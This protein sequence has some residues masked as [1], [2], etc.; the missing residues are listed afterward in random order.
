MLWCFDMCS[1]RPLFLA[2]PATNFVSKFWQAPLWS[3][4]LLASGSARPKHR[5][6]WRFFHSLCPL[7][8]ICLT[9][10]A[11]WI[12]P[13]KPTCGRC[14]VYRLQRLLLGRFTSGSFLANSNLLCLT[15]KFL[16]PCALHM[17]GQQQA[18]SE[19]RRTF[20]PV[21]I[22]FMMPMLLTSANVNIP[23][24]PHP[25][26][27]VASSTCAR[28]TETQLRSMQHVCNF[29]ERW[30]P[31]PT[32]PHPPKARKTQKSSRKHTGKYQRASQN[33]GHLGSRCTCLKRNFL[34]THQIAQQLKT[35][36]EWWLA[37]K[38]PQRKWRRC[39]IYTRMYAVMCSCLP[40]HSFYFH[41]CHSFHVF[42][43]SSHVTCFKSIFWHTLSAARDTPLQSY[44][45]RLLFQRSIALGEKADDRYQCVL[46][47]RPS[48][49]H[50][51]F[52]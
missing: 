27:G 1:W 2:R 29:S 39:H 3:L 17:A 9:I 15:W 47:L 37:D 14:I 10:Q 48:V 44:W 34:N 24:P 38:G 35:I 20:R 13:K 52:L 26:T 31:Q 22:W 40:F 33:K 30:H 43:H 11:E 28:A 16:I 19:Y 12:C 49:P 36:W 42:R 46:H 18:P 4:P 8:L 51:F 23:T 45:R 50:F 25:I 41:S 7:F 6:K 32:P 5:G 21:R